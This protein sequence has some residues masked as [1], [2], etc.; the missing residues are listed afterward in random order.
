MLVDKDGSL[1]EN[2]L[3]LRIF[4]SEREEVADKASGNAHVGMS[5]TM[6][7]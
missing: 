7:E 6:A 4:S 3:L 1:S 5:V 2:M